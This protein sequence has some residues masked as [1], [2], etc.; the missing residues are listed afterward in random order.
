MS[1]TVYFYILL[2]K[3]SEISIGVY[4]FS[5]SYLVY[6]GVFPEDCQ[7]D[8]NKLTVHFAISICLGP[9][10]SLENL[11]VDSSKRRIKLPEGSGSNLDFPLYLVSFHKQY[12]KSVLVLNEHKQNS[13]N[14]LLVLYIF[15][16][17]VL[18]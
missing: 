16:I 17:F 12:H 1:C 9:A 13:M 10:R 18:F 7:A 8:L 14:T 6:I 11:P 2:I 5:L 15:I 4:S 3:G